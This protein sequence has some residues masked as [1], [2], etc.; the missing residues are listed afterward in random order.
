MQCK[1]YNYSIMIILKIINNSDGD[2]DDNNHNNSD[3]NMMMKIHNIKL[4]IFK[5][6]S[7]IMMR[8]MMQ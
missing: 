6:L 3:D 8:I 1:D 5:L 2:D 7:T 4:I